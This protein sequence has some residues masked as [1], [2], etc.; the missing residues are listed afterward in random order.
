LKHQGNYIVIELGGLWS[1]SGSDTD[2]TFRHQVTIHGATVVHSRDKKVEQ[3]YS[4]VQSNT[5]RPPQAVSNGSSVL[6]AE[7][8]LQSD[9]ESNQE[10]MHGKRKKLERYLAT[11]RRMENHFEGFI[12]KHIERTKNIE[13]DE[14]AKAASRKKVLPPNVFFQVIKDPSVKIVEPEPRVVNTIQGED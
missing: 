8:R 3:Q 12:V 11:I 5:T 2:V 9:S 6:H 1:V 10:G 7:Y 4:R 14:L 13:V